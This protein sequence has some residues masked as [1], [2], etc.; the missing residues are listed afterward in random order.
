M[1]AITIAI[2]GGV[3]LIA[4]G[5]LRSAN[6]VLLAGS[7]NAASEAGVLLTVVSTQSNSTGTFVWVFNYGW[8]Q[9]GLTAVYVDGGL[10]RGWTSDCSMLPPK[11]MC[12]LQ[13]PA[14]TIGTVS[15]E[16]GTRTVSLSV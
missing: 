10:V 11:D 15:I 12:F 8:S 3:G 5:S 7:E 13:L 16:F 2:L 4:L 1:L 9:T 14:H 6:G